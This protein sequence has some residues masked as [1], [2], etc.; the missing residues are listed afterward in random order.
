MKARARRASATT[1]AVAFEPR[2]GPVPVIDGAR[3]A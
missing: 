2:G 3:G 1:H